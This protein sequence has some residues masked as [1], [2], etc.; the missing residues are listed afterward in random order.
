MFFCAA[1]TNLLMTS[2]WCEVGLRKMGHSEVFCHVGDDV[3]VTAPGGEQVPPLVTGSAPLP[4]P[5]KPLLTIPQPLAGR[6][7]CIRF[8]EKQLSKSLSIHTISSGLMLSQQAE[9]GQ[10]YCAER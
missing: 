5:V 3:Y 2:N 1:Y 6:T 8:W 9:P 10:C 4:L 7:L